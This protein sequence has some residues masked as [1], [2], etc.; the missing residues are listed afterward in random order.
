MHALAEHARALS[1]RIDRRLADARGFMMVTSIVTMLVVLGLITAVGTATIHLGSTSRR[2]DSSAQAL[3]AAQAGEQVA[4]FR[5]NTAGSATG[6][7]GALG[8]GASYSASVATLASQASSCTG[9]WVQNSSQTVNQDCITSTGT[10]NG[11]S[12]RVQERVAG[13]PPSLLFPV[14]GLFAVQSFSAANNVAGTFDLGSNGQMTF[15]NTIS[16]TGNLKYQP[17][18]LSETNNAC[19]TNCVPQQQTSLITVPSVPGS[20]YTAAKASNND[21][22]LSWGSQF[23]VNNSNFTV[24][25]NGANNVTVNIPAGTYYFCELNLGNATTL[26][27]TSWPV[28]I[29]VDSSNDGSDCSGVSPNGQMSGSNGFALANSSGTASNV[30]VYFYGQPGCTTACPNDFSPNSQTMT[31]DVFA[32]NSSST[33]GG[34]FTMT[35]AL[36][37]GQMTANNLLTFNYQSSSLTSGS[38]TNTAFYP[39]ANAVCVPGTGTC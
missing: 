23:T 34:A 8:N 6:A 2:T 1:S 35:G 21:A 24:N 20:T 4:L 19:H 33:P 5:L 7:T 17:G 32:P 15:T 18:K 36:V 22:A 9:L 30:Q 11:V 13:Y 28:K 25:S 26:N 29:Y 3:A 10:Q 38:S 16:L 39:S 31:A 27:T 14:S 37:I 12:E